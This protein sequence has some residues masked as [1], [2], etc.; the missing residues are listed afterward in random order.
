MENQPSGTNPSPLTDPMKPVVELLNG[1]PPDLVC[2]KYGINRAQLNDLIEAYQ[3]LQQRTALADQLVMQQVGRN[4]PCPC[5]S[6]KKYKKCCLPRHEEARTLIPPDRLQVM[7]ELA[8]ASQEIEKEMARGYGLLF[9]G[10]FAKASRLADQMLAVYPEDDRVHD[11]V[12]SVALA[13]GD[14]DRAHRTC[15][16]R[17][18]VSTEEKRFH[19]EHGYHQRAGKDGSKHVH[20]YS[21]GTWLETLWIAQ[22]AREHRTRFPQ[23]GDGKI[24][25][26]VLQLKAANDTNRFTGRQAEG[27]EERKRALAPA[28]KRLEEV[29]VEA[30]PYVLP[31]TYSFSWASLFVPELLRS[32]GTDDCV[33]L[34]AELSMFRFPYFAQ[35]CL[36]HLQSFGERAV[37]VIDRILQ[38]DPAFDGLKIG[39][40]SIL[41]DVHTAESFNILVRM[42]DHDDLYLVRWAARALESHENPDAAPHLER[43]K[44]RID[45]QSE[46]GA[47]IRELAGQ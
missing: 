19:Q 32:W 22:R 23:Q 5:G 43:A 14:Y 31:L 35:M 15:R 25:G 42:I 24:Q 3:T 45:Q 28:L 27:Y 44:A 40:L 8:R 41:A 1:T 9:A 37:P 10:E 20:F 6:G 16:G 7:D 26:L 2:S 39:L 13:T 46:I 11:L 29:G 12:V 30:I 4:E 21:P 47:A 18:Q 38:Q 17:W 36:S 33:G 34:L